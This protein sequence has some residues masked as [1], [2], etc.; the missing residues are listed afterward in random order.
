MTIKNVDLIIYGNIKQDFDRLSP[1][2]QYHETNVNKMKYI[3]IALQILYF[4]R[5]EGALLRLSF[6]IVLNEW[7][8]NRQQSRY[9]S[10]HMIKRK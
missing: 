7:K 9:K 1:C 10:I 2:R 8:T 4:F 6:D 3:Y 5:G